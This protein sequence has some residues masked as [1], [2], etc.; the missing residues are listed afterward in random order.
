M[1]VS[2]IEAEIFNNNQNRTYIIYSYVRTTS[3]HQLYEYIKTIMRLNQGTYRQKSKGKNTK[4]NCYITN[5]KLF[6]FKMCSLTCKTQ[7]SW[8]A[9]NGKWKGIP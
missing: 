7:D 6:D 2:S 8:Q 9:F 3:G 4:Q 1:S 5:Y